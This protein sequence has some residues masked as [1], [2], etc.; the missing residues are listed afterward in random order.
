VTYRYFPEHGDTSRHLTVT[1]GRVAGGAELEITHGDL[2][3]A[4]PIMPGDV[5]RVC[6]EIRAA[7]G[8]RAYDPLAG[9]GDPLVAYAR[10]ASMVRPGLVMTS[11]HRPVT[12]RPAAA[13]AAWS[14]CRARATGALGAL[15]YAA[16]LANY[17]MHQV[18]EWVQTGDTFEPQ[19]IL[20]RA[21]QSGLATY[22]RG[23]DGEGKAAASV[24]LV[25]AEAIAGEGDGK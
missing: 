25:I 16:A 2:S 14:F 11:T 24:R 18:G 10:A 21:G 20:T 15:L 23:L 4:L 17:G 7:A 5:E 6:A 3:A 1:G 12:H 8:V 13:Q 9:C 22:L 19:Q